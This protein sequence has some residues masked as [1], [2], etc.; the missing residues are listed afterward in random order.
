MVD[1]VLTDELLE[2][3]LFA[4]YIL[5]FLLSHPIILVNYSWHC[6]EY[7]SIIIWNPSVPSRSIPPTLF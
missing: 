2:G 4:L 1:V 3:L 7:L 6:A 5:L